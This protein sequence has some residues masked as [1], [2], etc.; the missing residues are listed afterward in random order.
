MSTGLYELF[1]KRG[2]YLKANGD[3]Q[4]FMLNTAISLGM[5]E[6]AA[7]SN[8]HTGW[9]QRGIDALKTGLPYANEALR[10]APTSIHVASI[11]EEDKNWRRCLL[12]IRRS[13]AKHNKPLRA[14]A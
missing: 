10:V 5:Y 2:D 7:Q 12:P 9:T 13:Y 3:I 4:G 14:F 8:Y 6:M 11:N 1:S